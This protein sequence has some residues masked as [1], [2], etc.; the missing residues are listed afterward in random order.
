MDFLW[1]RRGWIFRTTLILL[2]IVSAALLTTWWSI[3]QSL[4][5]LDG[6][7]KVAGI[8]NPVKIVRDADGVP[9]ITVQQR[10]DGAY[11]LGFLHAQE[12]F[13]QMDL[14]RR[15]A[16]GELAAILGEDVVSSDMHARRFRFRA[17]AEAALKSLQPA[18]LAVLERYAAGVNDGM[19]HLAVR[20]FEYLLLQSAPAP[21]KPA[22]SLLAIWSMY[23]S[24]QGDLEDRDLSRS[25]LKSKLTEEQLRFLLPESSEFDTTVDGVKIAVA[26]SVIPSQGPSWFASTDN[27]LAKAPQ[28]HAVGSNAWVVGGAHTKSGKP[29]V[30][31]DMH[32]DIRLPNTWYRAALNYRTGDKE[33]RLIGLTLPGVPAFVTGSNGAVAWGFTNS[34]GDY[35]D[36]IEMD[37]KL[38]PQ[39]TTK[40]LQQAGLAVAHEEAIQIRGQPPKMMTVFETDD[41]PI[42]QYHGKTYVV[43][44]LAMHP[45][46]VNL[47][48]MSLE[49]A[50]TVEEAIRLAAGIGIPSQNMLLADAGGSIGWTIAGLLPARSAGFEES[51][52]LR[53]RQGLVTAPVLDVSEYPKIVNPT[54]QLLWNGNNRQL[55]GTHYRKIGDGGADLGTR[56]LAIGNALMRESALSEQKALDISLVTRS[57]YATK[58]RES[59]LSVLD[60]QAIKASPLRQEFK[61]ILQRDT[62]LGA[63]LDSAAYVL[64]R[65]YADAVYVA[66]FG[67]IDQQMSKQQP[68]LSYSLANPRWMV[69]ALALLDRHPSGWLPNGKAWREVQLA[70]V[71]R[72]I[73]T[74][75]ANSSTLSELQWGKVN[76]SNI[77]HPFAE[78][79]PVFG[80]ALKAPNQPMPGDDNVPRVSA[81]DFGQ[82]ERLAVSP[83]NEA[84]GL[85]NMPGG[86]S[87]H[88]MSPYFLAGHDAWANGRSGALLPGREKYRLTLIPGGL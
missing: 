32:L 61:Q 34:Y 71:D 5:I 31:N 49:S 84:L 42:A 68:G 40:D 54:S 86:Q 63:D 80:G 29:I 39:A 85:F 78:L 48:L 37:H 58:W 7:L 83:G 17:R 75:M 50:T 81:P 25:W 76:T 10:D 4:P 8:A 36:L 46:A 60:E 52:P 35:L 82:S 9:F 67:A 55:D 33:R 15:S 44:W 14:L 3:R 22:D 20:P 79:L 62:A 57:D 43:S 77:Q 1:R 53:T 2:L 88:P 56:S 70:A 16:A 27:L 13:F 69:V 38:G 12:R 73:K 23:F 47:G 66:L 18:E 51:F 30:V 6:T 21:W 11:A 41:G 28:A 59:A 87:G 72:A 24:L 45:K 64:T 74:L 19:K 26:Q 65:A